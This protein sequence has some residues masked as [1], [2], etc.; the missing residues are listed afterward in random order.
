[1]MTRGHRITN[2]LQG[3]RR[4]KV[5]CQLCMAKQRAAAKFQEDMILTVVVQL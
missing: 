4:D 5:F 1:M 2:Q 3:A